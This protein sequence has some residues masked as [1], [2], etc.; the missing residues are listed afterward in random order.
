MNMPKKMPDP[1]NHHY[2]PKFLLEEFCEDKSPKL[3]VYDLEKEEIRNQIPQD[4]VFLG[5]FYNLLING[6][7]DKQLEKELR[8]LKAKQLQSLKTL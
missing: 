4:V 6:K 8:T 1:K 2:N 5:N 7:L 3:F